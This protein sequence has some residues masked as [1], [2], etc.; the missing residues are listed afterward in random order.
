MMTLLMTSAPVVMLDCNHFF[1]G[2]LI[3]LSGITIW[4]FWAARPA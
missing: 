3:A 1:I 2:A 4:H